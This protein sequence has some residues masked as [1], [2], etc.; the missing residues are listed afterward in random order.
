M[1]D[2]VAFNEFAANTA[3]D[4]FADDDDDLFLNEEEYEKAQPIGGGVDEFSRRK[5]AKFGPFSTDTFWKRSDDR[6][7][8]LKNHLWDFM[9]YNSIRELSF[10]NYKGQVEMMNSQLMLSIVECKKNVLNSL[11]NQIDL[12]KRDHSDPRLNN[13][14]VNSVEHELDDEHKKQ[15][16]ACLDKLIRVVMDRFRIKLDL[17]TPESHD[18]SGFEDTTKSQRTDNINRE[19]CEH[20]KSNKHVRHLFREFADYRRT[21][22][23]LI[24]KSLHELLKSFNEFRN[25]ILQE[26]Y[27]DSKGHNMNL[28]RFV[29]NMDKV[30]SRFDFFCE[31]RFHNLAT[32]FRNKEE[33]DN[34]IDSFVAF[35][36]FTH[37]FSEFTNNFNPNLKHTP[38]T[39]TTDRTTTDSATTSTVSNEP[40][41]AKTSKDKP[42]MNKKPEQ[43]P[44][45]TVTEADE[46]E[47]IFNFMGGNISQN[48]IQ[49]QDLS[50]NKQNPDGRGGDSGKD[51]DLD[52]GYE[53]MMDIDR[54]AVVESKKD[55]E[56]QKEEEDDL[57]L[58]Q[59]A[60]K[61]AAEILRLKR[62]ERMQSN[63]T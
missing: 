12:T 48:F 46:M 31:Y 7:H 15:V 43:M 13:S 25:K 54:D 26:V 60:R 33:V 22:N 34:Y 53:N 55:N 41:Q 29:K 45:T 49:T 20:L 14:S 39:A 63:Q 50:Q 38:T 32:Y 40:A 27:Q 11:N 24:R 30:T 61:K 3:D 21:K 8:D 28:T 35:N 57:K 51:M 16:E 59:E 42:Q 47:N 9:I 5:N 56:R 37:D 18:D 36:T 23:Q 4:L 52:Q 19:I 58:L 6:K 17:G 1:D 62:I 44:P 2:T 10:G